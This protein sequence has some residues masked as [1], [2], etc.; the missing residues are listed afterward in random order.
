MNYCT[1]N[2]N[3]AYGHGGSIY[4][5]G[6]ICNLSNCTLNSNTAGY[7]GGAIYNTGTCNLS[8]C[9]LNDNTAPHGGGAIVNNGNGALIAHFNRIVGNLASV[10]NAIFN[11]YGSIDSTFNWWGT[12]NPDWNSLIRGFTNPINW[13]ILTVNATPNTINNTQNTTITADFQPY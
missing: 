3:T 13:V 1:L 10:G 5:I 11:L 9:T 2:D 12:N 8:N 6:G 7:Y 4:N